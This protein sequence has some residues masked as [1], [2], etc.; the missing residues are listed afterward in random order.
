MKTK[1]QAG[2]YQIL[3]QLSLTNKQY[4]DAIQMLEKAVS[5]DPNIS[6]VYLLIGNAHAARK[7]FDA[8]IAQYGKALE[9]DPKSLQA[10]MLIG[11]VLDIRGERAKANTYYQRILDINRNFAPAANNLA[12]NYAE[13]GGDIDVALTLAQKARERNDSEPSYADTLGW[14][15]Y[16]KKVYNSAIEL[17]KESTAG[18]KDTNPTVLY[19]LG[20]A[21]RKIGNEML[22]KE[23]LGKSLRVGSKFAEL[24]DATNAMHEL[25]SGRGTQ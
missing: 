7:N 15:L 12:W 13:Y 2:V 21:Y 8:A 22:A 3:G 25:Q 11:I 6:S 17:F 10:Q 14:I 19:H 20:M 24:S 23:A 1:N 18:F 16:K 5:I 4:S 9:K